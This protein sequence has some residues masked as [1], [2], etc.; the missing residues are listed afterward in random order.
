VRGCSVAV[1]SEPWSITAE[2]GL[3]VF[4]ATILASHEDL[5]LLDMAGALYVATHESAFTVSFRSAR[6]SRRKAPPWGRDEWRGHGSAAM[7]EIGPV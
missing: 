1:V 4:S 2:D 5:L 7:A 3:N 6:S